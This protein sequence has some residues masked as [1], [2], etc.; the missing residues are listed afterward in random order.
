MDA[1]VIWVC[2]ALVLLLVP[3]CATGVRLALTHP[4]LS[5]D[6]RRLLLRVSGLLGLLALIDVELALALWLG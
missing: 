4:D 2:A 1:V 5:P 6:G 3:A